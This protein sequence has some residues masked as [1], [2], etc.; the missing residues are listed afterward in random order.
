MKKTFVRLS[1]PNQMK[2][3]AQKIFV[4][5]FRLIVMLLVSGFLFSTASAAPFSATIAYQP[6][7]S[8]G[9]AAGYPFEAWVVFDKNPDP[10]IPG[11]SLPAGA[12]F[13]FT[14]PEAF[15][16]QPSGPRPAAVLL[17]GWVHGAAHI[18][19]TIGLDPKDP[20]TVVLRLTES[21]PAGPPARP[22]LKAIHLRFGPLNPTKAGDYP[23]TIQLMDAGGLSGTTQSIAPITSKPVPNI[24]D[25][26]ALHDGR[27]ENWQRVKKGQPVA[28][29]IDLLVTLPDK[30]RS[31]I[32][33]RPNAEGN[34]DILS[35]M[36]PI[37]KIT[38]RGVPVTLKPEPFGPGQ[39]R[40]GIIRYY[41]T[42]GTESGIAEIEA[43]L[44]GGTH[45]KINVVIE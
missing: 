3:W 39:A 11:Y 44:Q 15:A 5:T 37:G 23:I 32:S 8:E 20:R 36:M 18:P 12:T 27:N 13:R 7:T 31:F 4:N 45:Y 6:M 22:G 10:T 26:N 21:F 41:V 28:L 17:Y 9:L 35:D 16:P 25:Y 38:R 1:E 42:A 30:A 33:L 34:L 19:F 14:F 24:A 29:P 2:E 43:E 40:L